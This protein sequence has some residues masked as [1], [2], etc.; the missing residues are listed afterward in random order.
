M[1]DIMHL[2]T[3]HAPADKVYRAI[4]MPEG[5]R[6]WWSRD[7]TL[8]PVIGASG[9]VRFYGGRFIA[10]LKVQELEPNCRVRWRVMNGAWHGKEI[11]FDLRAKGKDTTV[12]F[13]HR[14]FPDQDDGYAGATTRWGFYLVSL[15]RYLEKGQGTPN[16]DDGEA[17]G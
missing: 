3:I 10:M 1:A 6:E 12:E 4:T 7:V 17:F 2:I 5:M 15:K 16:P 9:E 8:K 11:I 14:G 13:A